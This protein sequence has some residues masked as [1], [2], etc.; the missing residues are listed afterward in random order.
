MFGKNL[1]KLILDRKESKTKFSAYLGI[2]RSTL[3]DYLNEV[4][5]MPS[6]KIE[7]TAAY[8][9]VTV[10]SIF[11]ETNQEAVSPK[12]INDQLSEINKKLTRLLNK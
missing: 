11:G 12:S 7:K 2:S 3:D 5:F 10:G 6:D 1:E 9:K 4:T 8:F